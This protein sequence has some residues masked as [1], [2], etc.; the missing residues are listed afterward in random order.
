MMGMLHGAE[1]FALLSLST[2]SSLITRTSTHLTKSRN[3]YIMRR[4]HSASQT[5]DDLTDTSAKSIIFP[6]RK[7]FLSSILTTTTLL[8]K[9]Q[10]AT[11]SYGDSSNI[12]M[13]NY[14]QFLIEK[15]TSVDPNKILY[16]GT[17]IDLQI[18][19]ISTAAQ[20]LNDIPPLAQA[21][22]WS[23]VQGILTGPLGTL[24]QTMN[25]ICKDVGGGKEVVAA[26]GKVKT[27]IILISQE[28]TKKNEGGVIQACSVA[29]KDL[30]AFAK[31]VF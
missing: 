9:S 16:K 13:P 23:Q 29:Q 8:A 20:R 30:E 21:K 5:D 3:P 11:A 15:N 27:G 10:F 1:A 31:L 14:I 18:Q 4:V 24:V 22:K 7:L 17:D 28:A 19:R 2:S 26:A 12:E 25:M 6:T